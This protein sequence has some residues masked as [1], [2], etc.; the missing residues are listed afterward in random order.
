MRSS[1]MTIP[2]NRALSRQ[3]ASMENKR[4]DLPLNLFFNR[5]I[6][7]TSRALPAMI[8]GMMAGI[9]DIT[10]L[11]EMKKAVTGVIRDRMIPHTRPPLSPARMMQALITGPVI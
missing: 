9:A 8:Q 7:E 1:E 2:I 10:G 11:P 5:Q 3:P 6:Q 4:P